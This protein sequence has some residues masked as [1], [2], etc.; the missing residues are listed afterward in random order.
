M[1]LKNGPQCLAPA[2]VPVP[3]AC[4]AL[5]KVAV[6]AVPSM[7]DLR[8]AAD[9]TVAAVVVPIPDSG[10]AA[11]D[12]AA[13]TAAAA[14]GRE[15]AEAGRAALAGT[16]SYRAAA[17]SCRAFAAAADIVGA[18][19]DKAANTVE[20]AVAAGKFDAASS[21]VGPAA[22]MPVLEPGA[23]TVVL[24]LVGGLPRAAPPPPALCLHPYSFQRTCRP[25]RTP[26]LDRCAGTS[27]TANFPVRLR[28]ST[29][30]FHW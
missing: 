8:M 2:S 21:T 15:F 7:Q 17:A 5:E 14:A 3:T 22:D 30:Q 1:V 29:R 24:E 27:T 25:C 23:D 11:P 19:L 4:R 10:R 6:P 26:G 9:K 28:T 20:A 13:D 16:A 12:P 18:R